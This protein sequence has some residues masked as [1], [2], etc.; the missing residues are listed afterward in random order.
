MVPAGIDQLNRL[1]AQRQ[2]HAIGVKDIGTTDIRLQL[3]G[4]QRSIAVA[5]G[6]AEEAGRHAAPASVVIEWSDDFLE[7]KASVAVS[8]EHVAGHLGNATVHIARDVLVRD[9]TGGVG[10][11]GSTFDVIPVAVAVNDIPHRYFE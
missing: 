1:A 11:N 2:L 9:E 8:I 5:V 3:R 4:R 7:F 10:E 6:G